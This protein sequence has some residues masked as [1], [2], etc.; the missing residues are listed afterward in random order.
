MFLEELSDDNQRA[1]G[2]EPKP[3]QPYRPKAKSAEAAKTQ[4]EFLARERAQGFTVI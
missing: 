1:S 2:E 4:Q 3:R